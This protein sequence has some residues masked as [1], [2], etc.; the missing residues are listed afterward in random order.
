MQAGEF[1]GAHMTMTGPQFQAPRCDCCNSLPA[2]TP[3]STQTDLCLHLQNQ[4]EAQGVASPTVSELHLQ[5]A[6]KALRKQQQQDGAPVPLPLAKVNMCVLYRTAQ[7]LT[8]G[9]FAAIHA[10][11]KSYQRLHATLQTDFVH[12]AV[13]G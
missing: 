13:A 6:Q 3:S 8:A 9:Q 1:R 12:V 5:H 11:H 2:C 4:I 7:L 10:G